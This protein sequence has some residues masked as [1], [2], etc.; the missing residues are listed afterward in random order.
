MANAC[1]HSFWRHDIQRNDIQYSDTQHK[2]TQY[3]Y[4]ECHHAVC[5][6]CRVSVMLRAANKPITLSVVV[7]NVVATSFLQLAGL[8]VDLF[9]YSC[10][11]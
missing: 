9:H 10:K 4:A 8:H 11:L 7:L 3:W 2:G 5:H 6:L 1:M